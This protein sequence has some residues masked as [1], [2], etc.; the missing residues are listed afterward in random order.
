MN[1][2][3]SQTCWRTLELTAV[4]WAPLP[5]ARD[6]LSLWSCPAH[7]KEWLACLRPGLSYPA[8]SKRDF[9]ACFLGWKRIKG[10]T[11]GKHL[12]VNQK[13]AANTSQRT[14]TWGS[15]FEHTQEKSHFG[16]LLGGSSGFCGSGNEAPVPKSSCYCSEWNGVLL[17]NKWMWLAG[18]GA[19]L[20][21]SSHSSL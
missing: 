11:Q 8:S 16:E 13:A 18:I 20:F 6:M 15:T 14:V 9:L 2:S 12:T 3:V 21:L 1:T 19:C 7:L 4:S 5:L 17:R 10:F